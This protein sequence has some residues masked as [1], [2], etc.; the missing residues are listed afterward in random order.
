MAGGAKATTCFSS[1]E[2]PA[3]PSTVPALKIISLAL[4]DLAQ[5]PSD[6]DCTAL[7]SKAAYMLAVALPSTASISTRRSHSPNPYA[8]PSST[9]TPIIALTISSP[10]PIG[11]NPSCT[12]PSPLFLPSPTASRASSP[13][14]VRATPLPFLSNL[15]FP[16]PLP[17]QEVSIRGPSENFVCKVGEARNQWIEKPCNCLEYLMWFHYRN[18]YTSA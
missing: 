5:T 16:D 17:L 1:T 3:P 9:A 4:G 12:L 18:R 14:A 11:T 15:I 8:P 10:L 13:Q 7:L 2:N 6:T